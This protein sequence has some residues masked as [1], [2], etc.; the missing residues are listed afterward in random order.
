[1]PNKLNKPLSPNE[2]LRHTLEVM[3]VINSMRKERPHYPEDD[4]YPWIILKM[5]N[6]PTKPDSKKI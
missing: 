2:A 6:N 1:M 3:N 5:K 4:E